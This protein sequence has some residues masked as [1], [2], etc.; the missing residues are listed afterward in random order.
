MS[1]IEATSLNSFFFTK[2]PGTRPCVC[3]I[4]LPARP[5]AGEGGNIYQIHALT[6]FLSLSMEPVLLLS[7]QYLDPD[8]YSEYG[9]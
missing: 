9:S 8:Q 3:G 2:A 5:P 4:C 6:F 1:I 7:F